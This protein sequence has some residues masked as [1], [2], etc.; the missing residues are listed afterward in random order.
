[1]R[2][3]PIGFAV[4]AAVVVGSIPLRPNDRLEW[5]LLLRVGRDG[6]VR[7]WGRDADRAR[8]IDSGERAVRFTA[9]GPG[10]NFD[11]HLRLTRLVAQEVARIPGRRSKPVT[12]RIESHPLTPFA[13]LDHIHAA[14]WG[15][16]ARRPRRFEFSTRGRSETHVLG[17]PANAEPVDITDKYELWLDVADP[18]SRRE[19]II[20][21]LNPRRASSASWRTGRLNLTR[22]LPLDV[23]LTLGS[24]DALVGPFREADEASPSEVAISF[25]LNAMRRFRDDRPPPSWRL[26]TRVVLDLWARLRNERMCA[27]VTLALGSR[28]HWPPP[29]AWR[30][31]MNA[32]R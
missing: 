12:L 22:R 5:D 10:E 21:F 29:D 16:G 15:V 9:D 14:G 13:V 4:F 26:P 24:L 30:E 25:H 18:P 28:L 3:C 11:G 23:D 7:V 27:E 31:R 8:R 32:R 19:L 20:R 2:W 17:V 1:M 6:T